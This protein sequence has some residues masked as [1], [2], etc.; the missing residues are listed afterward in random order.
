MLDHSHYFPVTRQ[1]CQ[2]ILRDIQMNALLQIYPIF[3]DNARAFLAFASSSMASFT[4]YG[5]ILKPADSHSH[6]GLSV[7]RAE[8]VCGEN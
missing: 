8:G 6:A 5:E 1:L 2:W 4:D 7:E 3:S